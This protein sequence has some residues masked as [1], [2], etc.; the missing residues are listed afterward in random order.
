MNTKNKTRTIALILVGGFSSRMGEDKSFLRVRSNFDSK[1]FLQSVLQR[2]SFLCETVYISLRKEQVSDYLSAISPENLILDEELPLEGPLKGI[3]STYRFL[4]KNGTMESIL[5]VPVDMPLVRIRTLERL[6]REQV[7]SQIGVFYKTENQLEPLCGLYHSQT[8][9]N[10]S[11]LLDSGRLS[12][13]SPKELL[14]KLGP[15]LLELPENE[16][17]FFRNVN[18]PS[19][20]QNL[21]PKSTD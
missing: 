10:L 4:K 19:E 20:H 1:T 21:T 7:S 5:V 16:K 12:T 2:V 3:L 15:R 6:I 13:F 18:T 11:R 17:K 9:D 14:E 8:L